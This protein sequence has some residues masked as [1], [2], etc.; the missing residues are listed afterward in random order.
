VGKTLRECNWMQALE[1]DIDNAHVPFLHG[2]LDFRPEEGSATRFYGR[3]MHLEAADTEYGAMYGV[4]REGE[5]GE[6][7]WRIIQFLFPS[8]SMITIGTPRERGVVPSH[9]WVPMDDEHT[10]QWGIKWHPTEP[11]P[12][13]VS[14]Q[15]PSDYLP[16]GSGWLD[17]W[18]PTANRTNDY[19]IDREV[20]RTVSFSGIP[21][22]PL[23]D[24]M[25]TE[26]MGP[27][28]DRAHEHL[29][30]T[31]A[32]II[33]VRRRLI[34]AAKALRDEGMTPPGVDRPEIYRV[35][36][37]IVNLPKAADWVQATREVVKATGSKAER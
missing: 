17:Q 3:P 35:R 24:K 36:S 28:V 32:M 27:I 29:G 9:M 6:Y 31:D 25:A 7:N 23:Q 2:Q 8:F 15:T 14:A 1:G 10:M 12:E 5:E 21:S 16:H 4:R 26:S 18:Q 20:Q 19:L 30:T 11:L 22:I 33:R 34:E 37:A 13:G